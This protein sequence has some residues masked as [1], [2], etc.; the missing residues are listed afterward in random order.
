VNKGESMFTIHQFTIPVLKLN[1]PIYLIPV[2]DVHRY[3][4]LCDVKKWKEFLVWAKGKPRAYYLLMGDMDDLCSFSERRI[5]MDTALHEETRYTLDEIYQQRTD[6][7]VKEVEFMRGRIIGAIEGNHFGVFQ[8]GITTTQMM[9]D[10]LKCKYL[11]CS[12]FIRLTFVHGSKR[13]S[14]D[15]WAH[16]GKGASR[17]VG[18]SLNSVQQMID[19]GEADIYLQGHDHKKGVAMKTR[20][21]LTSGRVLGLSHQKILMGRTGSFLRGYVPDESSYVCRGLMSPTDLG[22]IKIELTPK[23]EKK[24]GQD[25][26][27][28]DIH[29]S[30]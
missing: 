21:R 29:S 25:I 12:A 20:L 9:C 11:G 13:A 5:L 27:Y 2:G 7:L 22:T 14:I 15:I 26:F 3:A 6:S 30:L 8:S 24:H 23:R 17:L 4:H 10:K 28:I 19:M 16:H 18:G 1:E